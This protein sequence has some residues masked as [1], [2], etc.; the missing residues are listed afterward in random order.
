MSVRGGLFIKMEE[1]F[2]SVNGKMGEEDNQNAIVVNLNKSLVIN[3]AGKSGGAGKVGIIR[4]QSVSGGVDVE[5]LITKGFEEGRRG[6]R[7]F[8]NTGTRAL[9]R[10]QGEAYVR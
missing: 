6:R 1:V 9:D 2:G 8:G 5:G 10:L 7:G 4:G 3:K